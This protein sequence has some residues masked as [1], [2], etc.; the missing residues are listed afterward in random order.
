VFPGNSQE[1]QLKL[2]QRRDRRR[3]FASSTAATQES[4]SDVESEVEDSKSTKASARA[5]KPHVD[6]MEEEI[7]RRKVKDVSV[8][9]FLS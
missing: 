5:S 9:K 2:K 3:D 1:Q 6:P 8:V 7:K 4:S